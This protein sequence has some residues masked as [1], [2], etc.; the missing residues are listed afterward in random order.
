MGGHGGVS[1]PLRDGMPHPAS[2]AK[3]LTLSKGNHQK[4]AKMPRWSQEGVP[5]WNK[6]SSEVPNYG[7]L[8]GGVITKSQN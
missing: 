7:E 8:N 2:L 1:R 4:L 3:S 6:A 5:G